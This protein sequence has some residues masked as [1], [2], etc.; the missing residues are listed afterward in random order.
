[1]KRFIP[2]MYQK[3][4][5]SI[6]YK[7]IKDKG[8]KLIIFDLDNTI[9]S[10]KEEICNQKT[11]DF[12]NKLTNDFKVVVVSNS[13]KARVRKFCSN[14]NC[15]F[16]A[17]SL[18]PS[19]RN[20]RKVKRKY[21]VS[22]KEMIIIGDQIITDILGGN[23]LGLLTILVDPINVDLKVTGINRKL[24]KIINRKNNIVKGVYYEEN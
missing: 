18:K 8:Y 21:N 2:K 11:A 24:E 19:T 13:F 3:D 7:K 9:G 12:I 20:I 22:Y 10:I 6:D 4:I 5:F 17:F 15:D 14:L 23:R 1:M 16:F